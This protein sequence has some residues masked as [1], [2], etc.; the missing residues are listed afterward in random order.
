VAALRRH[1]VATPRGPSFGNGRYAR[2][3]MDAAV[4]RHAKRLRLASSPTLEDLCLLLPDD[5][6]DPA[7]LTRA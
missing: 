1:F 5:V 6:P 2:Q 3:V 7:Q 4:T